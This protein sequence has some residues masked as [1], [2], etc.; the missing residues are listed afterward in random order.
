MRFG[1]Q[2]WNMGECADIRAI[3]DLAARAESVGWDGVFVTDHLTIDGSTR[4]CDPWMQLAAIAMETERVRLGPMVTALPRRHPGKLAQEV[5]TLDHLSGGRVIFGAGAGSLDYPESTA[6]GE[7]A[8]PRTRAEIVDETLE[9][10]SQLWSDGA[11]EFD[12]VHVKAHLKSSSSTCQR[13]RVPIWL[14][15]TWPKKRPFRR[16]ARWDGAFPMKPDAMAG[17]VTTPEETEAIIEYVSRHRDPGRAYDVVYAAAAA[18]GIDPTVV[19]KH[20]EAGATWFIAAATPFET[21]DDI[22]RH[23]EAGPPQI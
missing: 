8:N 22:R 13:P 15:G 3:A 10:L 19:A 6:F 1:F 18:L 11:A 7:P 14:A 5:A 17:G 2:V 16:A 21:I 9:V 23:I 12:G 20:A 4:S